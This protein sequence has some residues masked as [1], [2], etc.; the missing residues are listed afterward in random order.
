VTAQNRMAIDNEA[1]NKPWQ[2]P[3][4]QDCE[5]KWDAKNNRGRYARR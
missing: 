1:P 2:C 5:K 4:N 3:N